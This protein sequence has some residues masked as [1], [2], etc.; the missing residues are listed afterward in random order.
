MTRMLSYSSYHLTC[1][2]AYV[3]L[4]LS[5]Y[6]THDRSMEGG[7]MKIASEQESRLD[8]S[9]KLAFPSAPVSFGGPSATEN[10]HILHGF[11]EVDGSQKLCPG[12]YI[13]GTE[14]LMNEVRINRFDPRNAL[15]A[16]GHSVSAGLSLDTGV[17]HST[18]N[19]TNAT[20]LI[21][22]CFSGM[23]SWAAGL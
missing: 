11:G 15:F 6:C 10:F 20:I 1:S 19:T 8:L 2:H 5:L 21:A 22:L 16:K 14:A 13:G 12:V 18:A 23:G 7:L 9:L 17:S 3:H 4:F